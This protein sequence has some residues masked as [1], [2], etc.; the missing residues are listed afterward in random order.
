MKRITFLPLIAALMVVVGITGTAMAQAPQVPSLVTQQLRLSNGSNAYINLRAGTGPV[1]SDLAPGPYFLDAPPATSVGTSYV[2]GLN[3]L[4]HIVRSTGYGLVAGQV[5]PGIGGA[6]WLLRVNITGDGTEWI[7]PTDLTGA[8]NGLVVD[9]TSVVGTA[10]VQLGGNTSLAGAA[11]PFTSDRFVNLAT[12]ALN[13]EGGGAFNIGIAGAVTNMTFDQGLTGNITM[14][15]VPAPL[16]ATYL[17]TDRLLFLDA[18]NHVNTRTLASL[19]DANNGLVVD[20]TGAIPTIQLG[21]PSAATGTAVAFAGDRFVDFGTH[22]LNFQGVGTMTVGD[23]TSNTII[24]IDQGTTVGGSLNLKHVTPLAPLSVAADNRFVVMTAGSD[25]VF[26]R[27]LSTLV[28]ANNGLIVDNVTV[29][30]TSTV[31]IGGPAT[32]TAAPLVRNSFVDMGAFTMQYQG[33]GPFTVGDGTVAT[34]VNLDQ[35]T[36]AGAINLKHVDPMT[37]GIGGDVAAD[38]RFVTMTATGDKVFTRQLSSLVAADQGLIVDNT[39]TPGTS[40]VMLG[41]LASGTNP[42]NVARFVTQTA[43]AGGLTFDGSGSINILGTSGGTM[44][45]NVNTNGANV[46]VNTGAG[47]MTLQGTNLATPPV[48]T[49]TDPTLSNFHNLAYVEE[50]GHVVHTITAA[51]MTRNDA[52][53]DFVAIDPG[54]GNFVKAVSPTAGIYRGQQAWTGWQQTFSIPGAIAANASVVATIQNMS[55]AGTVSIQVTGYTTGA[56]GTCTISIETSDVPPAA[57]SFIN[58]IVMNP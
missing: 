23:G 28:N 56:A 45:L 15:N 24:N 11:V 25:Q 37:T 42:I 46:D 55:S 1:N 40:T 53:A 32:G 10:I 3:N 18:A 43:P 54:T 22:A 12:H 44:L 35:G 19:V 26:T 9:N 8:N 4:N 6:G 33:A 36:S 41:A 58:W 57:G 7:Q 20:I 48:A 52:P 2:L 47:N 51:N 38:N 31:Q 39:V 5:G 50:T 34:T 17:N 30:G 49:P 27:D 29:P 16:P 13:F 21:G 14:P